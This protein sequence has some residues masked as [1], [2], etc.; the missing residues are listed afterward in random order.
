MDMEQ[1]V[2]VKLDG[3]HRYLSGG[4]EEDKENLT[5]DSRSPG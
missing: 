3:L 5:P 1:S 4:T 2:V